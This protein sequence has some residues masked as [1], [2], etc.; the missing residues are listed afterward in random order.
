MPFI[1][2]IYRSMEQKAGFVE[3]SLLNFD[4]AMRYFTS[5]S[6]D[7]RELI[8]LFPGLLSKSTNFRRGHPPLHEFADVAQ[9][10]HNDLKKMEDLKAFL[11]RFLEVHRSQYDHKKVL[12][13]LRT[14]SCWSCAASPI[15]CLLP[16]SRTSIPP[17]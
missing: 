3:F 6:L 5:G 12:L 15:D 17:S 4:N 10:T 9:I 1:L 2:Q 7:P 11:T 13:M 14:R 8:S 16:L